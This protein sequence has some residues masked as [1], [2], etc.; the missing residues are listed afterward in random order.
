MVTAQD[1]SRPP[2]KSGNGEARGIYLCRLLN[3][4][5]LGQPITAGYVSEQREMMRE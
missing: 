2:R 1:A 3:K 5:G 4:I